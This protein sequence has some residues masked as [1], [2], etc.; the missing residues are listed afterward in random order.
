MY[1]DYGKGSTDAKNNLIGA[2]QATGIYDLEA[3]ANHFIKKFHAGNLGKIALD[4][5][6]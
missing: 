1:H 3:A 5:V 2:K 6:P 4:D